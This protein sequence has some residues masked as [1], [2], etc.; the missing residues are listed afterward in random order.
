MKKKLKQVF[1]VVMA[2]AMVLSLSVTAGANSSV[3]SGGTFKPDIE[4]DSGGTVTTLG[5]SGSLNAGSTSEGPLPEDPIELI[6]PTIPANPGRDDGVDS[7]GDFTI[8]DIILDP[9]SLIN[10]TGGARYASSGITKNFSEDSRLYFLKSF[11]DTVHNYDGES[12]PLEITNKGRKPVSVNL[13]LNFDYDADNIKLVSG[14]GLTMTSG[15]EMSPYGAEMYFGLVVGAGDDKVSYAVTDPAV[16]GAT[17]AP[18][19]TVDGKGDYIDAFTLSGDGME[20]ETPSV[21]FDISHD[22]EDVIKD[23]LTNLTVKLTYEAP[24]T[25]KSGGELQYGAIHVMPTESSGALTI[26]GDSVTSDGEIVMTTSGDAVFNISTTSGDATLTIKLMAPNPRTMKS[27][28][29][30]A[31]NI[32]FKKREAGVIVQTAI[33][34]NEDGYEEKWQKPDDDST[35]NPQGMTSN[36]YFWNLKENYN[37]FPVLTFRLEGDINNDDT[38]DSMDTT[39]GVTFELIWDVMQYSTY[40]S[41]VKIGDGE[42]ETPPAPITPTNGTQPKLTVTTKAS[43]SAKLVLTLTAGTLDYEGYTPKLENDKVTMTLSNGKGPVLLTYAASTGRLTGTSTGTSASSDYTVIAA[44]G[45]KGT[46]TLVKA[47]YED[48]TVSISGMRN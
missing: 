42:P 34:G 15:D 30:F 35:K 18:F 1:A 19:V 40:Y 23:N 36:G 46:I 20:I 45:T 47:G 31:Q 33:D 13:S 5:A 43:S 17:P 8:Y 6:F 16:D 26:S 38:W 2:V 10:K 29:D 32:H 4:T 27:G 3:G 37:D 14:D 24:A 11:T 9:H 22:E 7:G 48:I 28:D 39:P 21:N 41:N 25:V 44:S 12:Y